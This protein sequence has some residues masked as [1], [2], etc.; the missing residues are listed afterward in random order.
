MMGLVIGK[1]LSV[2][3]HT[4]VIEFVVVKIKMYGL[5]YDTEEL[6]Q[7]LRSGDMDRDVTISRRFLKKVSMNYVVIFIFVCLLCGDV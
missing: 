5:V 7:D 4:C 2:T 6:L 3:R 1:C